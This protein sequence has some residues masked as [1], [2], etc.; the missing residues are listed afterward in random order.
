MENQLEESS[1]KPLQQLQ[2]RMVHPSSRTSLNNRLLLIQ[3]IYQA[4]KTMFRR[5]T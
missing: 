5:L 4:H 3:G 2:G 1:G